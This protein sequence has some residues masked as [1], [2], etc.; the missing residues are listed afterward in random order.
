M[1]TDAVLDTV[2][3]RSDRYRLGHT[4]RSLKRNGSNI[5][6][7]IAA[8]F[9]GL[10]MAKLCSGTQFRIH[11]LAEN[12]RKRSFSPNL[13]ATVGFPKMLSGLFSPFW[14]LICR[15]ENKRFFSVVNFWGDRSAKKTTVFL[16]NLKQIFYRNEPSGASD[17]D[18]L[19]YARYAIR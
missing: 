7:W 16:H 1:T 8:L 11:S 2:L 18:R 19:E 10:S 9:Y 6:S 3:V 13:Q 12:F 4:T 15:S 5:V 14:R 17:I